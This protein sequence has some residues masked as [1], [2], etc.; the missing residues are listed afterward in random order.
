MANDSEVF[1]MKVINREL[2]EVEAWYEQ[3]VTG[4]AEGGAENTMVNFTL[5]VTSYCY[6]D[7]FYANEIMPSSETDRYKEYRSVHGYPVLFIEQV[8]DSK[9]HQIS[10]P[11]SRFKNK[12]NRK[13]P[14]ESMVISKVISS[15]GSVIE[16]IDYLSSFFFNTPL[17]AFTI[18]ATAAEYTNAKIYFRAYNGYITGGDEKSYIIDLTLYG[19]AGFIYPPLPSYLFA[20]VMVNKTIDPVFRMP[21]AKSGTQKIELAEINPVKPSDWEC[22]ACL[23]PKFDP[24]TSELMINV[25]TTNVSIGAQQSGMFNITLHLWDK[26]GE[27][28]EFY[29]AFDLSLLKAGNTTD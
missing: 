11:I 10:I 20:E 8:V 18:S 24:R 14:L 7:V 26:L 17:Q 15:M 1:L 25:D 16:P 28:K 21:P 2:W 5:N 12:Y 13:C 6:E 4:R 29:I 23:I 22:I 27:I 9:K 3:N 19:P